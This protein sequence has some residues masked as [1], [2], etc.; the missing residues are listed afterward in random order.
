MF[1]EILYFIAPILLRLSSC[2]T[3]NVPLILIIIVILLTLIAAEINSALTFQSD[4]P[5][6]VDIDLIIL[7]NVCNNL[8]KLFIY[9]FFFLKFFYT[10]LFFN[11]KI[12]TKHEMKVR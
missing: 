7:H 4:Q 9:T 6:E 8:M 1:A 10:L 11:K 12:N 2:Y 3:L 5:V